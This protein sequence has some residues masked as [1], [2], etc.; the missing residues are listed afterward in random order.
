MA[1]RR[2]LGRAQAHLAAATGAAVLATG[3]SSA[4]SGLGIEVVAVGLR[5]LSSFGEDAAGEVYLVSRGDGA[6]YKLVRR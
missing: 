1:R 3:A 2:D 6:V 5:Q 4:G